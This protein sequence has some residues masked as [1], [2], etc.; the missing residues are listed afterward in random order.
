MATT[1]SIA[2]REAALAPG[3]RLEGERSRRALAGVLAFIARL[4]SR[5][6]AGAVFAVIATLCALGIAHNLEPSPF[7]MD[8]EAVP[9]AY[10]SALLLWAAAGLALLAVP[11]GAIPARR[12]RN[13]LF[14]GGLF[15]FMGLDEWRAIHETLESTTSINWEILYLPIVIPAGVA[16]LAIVS[17]LWRE[18]RLAASMMIGGAIC[19]VLAQ[20][21]ENYQ[22]GSGLHESDVLL[23]PGTIPAEETLEMSGSALFGLALMLVIQRTLRK[24]ARS[25]TST[26][27]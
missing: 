23:H 3:F 6:V 17:T 13:W 20:G 2:A 16:W 8:S 1:S 5:L 12:T 7:N 15:A 26:G 4:D 22:W 14:L 9:P 21:L 11:A 10:W 25:V 27:G 24:R 19:W 18:H